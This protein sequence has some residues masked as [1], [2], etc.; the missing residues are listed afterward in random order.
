MDSWPVGYHS[1]AN[2]LIPIDP[3]EPLHHPD[4]N[5]DPTVANVR[6]VSSPPM[7]SMAGGKP[8][9]P[10]VSVPSNVEG[11]PLARPTLPSTRVV[12][13]NRQISTAGP[14]IVYVPPTNMNI[15]NPPLS[16]RQDLGAQPIINQA[17]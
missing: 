16:P 7:S 10:V 6:C 13:H 3:V 11:K 2:S 1:L 14:S 5:F 15:V 4:Q 8:S 12:T 9:T 17:S